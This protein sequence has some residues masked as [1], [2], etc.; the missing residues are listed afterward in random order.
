MKSYLFINIC[1]FLQP[2]Y[3][4]DCQQDPNPALLE[5]NWEVA[6]Q[7]ILKQKK[8]IPN[9]QQQNRRIKSKIEC[10]KTL[11]EFLKEIYDLTDTAEIT[12]RVSMK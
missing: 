5:G 3:Y 6:K 1:R 4:G 2:R 8:K 7:C 9:L 10:Q 12:L 11:L